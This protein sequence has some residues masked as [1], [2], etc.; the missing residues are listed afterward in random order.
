M[1]RASRCG[2]DGACV[3]GADGTRRE[4]LQTLFVLIIS[5]DFTERVHLA[6]H[7]LV[8]NPLCWCGARLHFSAHLWRT[9]NLSNSTSCV[10][11]GAFGSTKLFVAAHV[12]YRHTLK[13]REITLLVCPS[14]AC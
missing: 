8:A 11:F 2:T 12:P 5:D 10:F 1:Q 13:R 9:Q 3:C 6:G 4:R 7:I 14:H